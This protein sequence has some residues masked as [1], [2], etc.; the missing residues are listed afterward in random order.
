[1]TRAWPSFVLDTLR[2]GLASNRT[3]RR[4]QPEN[5]SFDFE[6]VLKAAHRVWGPMFEEYAQ[7]KLGP[8]Y[9]PVLGDQFDIS[10][11]K[12]WQ[13]D[14]LG[15]GSGKEAWEEFAEDYQ[16]YMN[17]E[18][19]GKLQKPHLLVAEIGLT[20]QTL[21]KK[22]ADKAKSL[23][24]LDDFV[25]SVKARGFTA[26]KCSVYDGADAEDF[27]Q[28]ESRGENL[29]GYRGCVSEHPLP[30]SRDRLGQVRR[31]RQAEGGDGQA[32]GEDRRVDRDHQRPRCPKAVLV[33]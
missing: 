14:F 11:G 30:L 5:A 33:L 22:F 1:M 26:V 16:T 10:N 3:A 13:I 9:E 15:V 18:S 21:K 23:Q 2:F 4:A 29:P 19:E 20:T 17:E 28:T 8:M 24:V 31:D 27:T 6:P 32:D 7:R 25:T 12:H